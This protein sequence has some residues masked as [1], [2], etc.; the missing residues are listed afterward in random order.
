MSRKKNTNQE[1]L[2]K[3]R[4]IQN[5]EKCIRTMSRVSFPHPPGRKTIKKFEGVPW[6]LSG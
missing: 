1:E 4:V 6:W 2:K 3:K 5:K